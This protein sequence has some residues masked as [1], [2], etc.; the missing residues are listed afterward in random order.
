MRPPIKELTF[1]EFEQELV[2]EF[3][4]IFNSAAEMYTPLI[5]ENP[6]KIKYE[7]IKDNPRGEEQEEIQWLSR[8][9]HN[10][11]LSELRQFIETGIGDPK[12]QKDFPDAIRYLAR[13]DE[14]MIEVETCC[15]TGDRVNLAAGYYAY[16]HYWDMWHGVKEENF[17]RTDS[18]NFN[19]PIQSSINMCREK[20]SEENNK[21]ESFIEYFAM[22]SDLRSRLL[23]VFTVL[24]E[25]I[26]CKQ[27]INIK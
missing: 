7:C 16:L 9:I 3:K 17:K 22:R 8:R 1:K 20:L 10:D 27:I 18:I 14:K 19:D 12:L 2:E 15:L 23:S 24:G 6:Y 4:I 21:G 25:I 11:L 5:N 26:F 13:N